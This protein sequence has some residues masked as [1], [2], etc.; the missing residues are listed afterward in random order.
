MFWVFFLRIM[1]NFLILRVR[2][3]NFNSCENQLGIFLFINDFMK[4]NKGFKIV[5]RVQ[6]KI[7]YIVYF[8]LFINFVFVYV[9]RIEFIILEGEE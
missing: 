3:L 5:F 7:V 9:C 4:F 6:F 1:F 8:I 2:L